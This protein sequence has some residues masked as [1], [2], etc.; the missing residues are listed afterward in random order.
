MEA[1]NR[2]LKLK[3][4]SF[5]KWSAVDAVKPDVELYV[6]RISG[7]GLDTRMFLRPA[8]VTSKTAELRR[9]EHLNGGGPSAGARENGKKVE[10]DPAPPQA[11]ER[12]QSPGLLRSISRSR[13]RPAA[14]RRRSASRSYSRSY[15]RSRSGGAGRGGRSRSGSRRGA[16]RKGRAGT[17]ARREGKS[18]G[19]GKGGDDGEEVTT[20]FVT[21]LPEDASEREVREDFE[22][23]GSHVERIVLMRRGAETNAFVRF[24]DVG[25]AK[26]ELEKI[27]SSR[28]KICD[29]KVKAE[30]ARRNTN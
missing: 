14:D 26:R 6:A 24:K 4:V 10:S 8:G 3:E 18:K 1:G 9:V 12:R 22:E 15:S 2:E 30:M 20:I 19:G 27:Q 23:N 5:N 29:R 17:G 13:G 7:Y 25:E 11:Q 21:G 16:G 28:G